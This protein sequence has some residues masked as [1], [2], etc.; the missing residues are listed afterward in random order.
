MANNLHANTQEQLIAT[1]QIRKIASGALNYEPS[2]M[3]IHTNIPN[4][5]LN[6]QHKIWSYWSTSDQTPEHC[7]IETKNQSS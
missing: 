6:L 7:N 5:F 4:I 3:K 1:T 2:K